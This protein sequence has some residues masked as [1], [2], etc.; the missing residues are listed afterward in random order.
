[1]RRLTRGQRFHTPPT[2]APDGHVLMGMR[3]RD[4]RWEQH[5]VSLTAEGMAAQNR[6]RMDTPCL[7]PQWVVQ[8]V[9]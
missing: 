4:A 1:L 5:M 9:P 2:W 7:A 3:L 6:F 8:R